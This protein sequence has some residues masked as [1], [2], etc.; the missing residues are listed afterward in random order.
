MFIGLFRG[1]LCG[2][3]VM[4]RACTGNGSV[5]RAPP[6][7]PHLRFCERYTLAND[8]L[9][10]FGSV[11]DP[12]LIFRYLGVRVKSSRQ[13]ANACNGR[14]PRRKGLQSRDE[15]GFPASAGLLGP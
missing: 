4:A 10:T 6:S 2:L 7:R 1:V 9:K 3:G 5:E 8:I 11:P 15:I 14:L 13:A 12:R